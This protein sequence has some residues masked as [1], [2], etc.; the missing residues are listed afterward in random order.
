MKLIDKCT[1]LN[2]KKLEFKYGER[3]YIIKDINLKDKEFLL[4]GFANYIKISVFM[5]YEDFYLFL[6]DF[7][8]EYIYNL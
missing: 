1:F 4:E 8:P 5:N 3:V 7:F 6:Y 2:E